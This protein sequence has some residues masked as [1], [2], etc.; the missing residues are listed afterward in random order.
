[1][2]SCQWCGAQ[3]YAIDSWCA[4]CSRHLDFAP[5]S[6]PAAP[7][8][9]LV[10][11]V[12]VERLEARRPHPRRG[13][14]LLVPAAAGVG[15]AIALAL[16]AASWFNTARQAPTPALPN[17][18]MRPAAAPT[19]YAAPTS[20]AMPTPDQ[21][22]T[23]NSSPVDETIPPPD[24]A[25]PA[26]LTQPGEALVPTGGDPAATVARFYQAVSAHDFAAAAALW[27]PRMQAQYP[28][29]EYI[30]HRFAATRQINVRAERLLGDSGGLATVSVDVAEVIGG[31]S[32][33]WVGTWE[34]VDS[35]SGWLLNRPNLRAAT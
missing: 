8:P 7:R 14:R 12:R 9:P 13:L 22:S 31:Q 2:I 10:P 29:A 21:S 5:P 25:P 17:T 26:D 32:R 28:P 11:T 4:S 16:P 27:T 3:N 30:D 33:H 1:M 20:Y 34:L 6:P 24:A 15:L 23:Q 19:P 35:A 18:A